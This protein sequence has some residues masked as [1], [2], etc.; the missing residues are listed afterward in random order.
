MIKEKNSDEALQEKYME[1]KMLQHQIEKVREQVK[2]FE[3]QI[4]E[5]GGVTE[6]LKE[7]EHVEKGTEILVPIAGGI[8]ITA[9]IKDT[10]KVAVNVGAN[11]VVQ[12]GFAE[13]QQLMD[14]Q[15]QEI[16]KYREELMGQLAKLIT[17][18]KQL[19]GE[20]RKLVE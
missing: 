11:T 12:K 19:Q 17:H 5:L 16:M 9:E 6:H 13:A 4:E 8:F 3:T 20:L 15:A 14:T 1:F 2:A 18:A 7:L 10:T